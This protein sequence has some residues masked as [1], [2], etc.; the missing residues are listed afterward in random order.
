[1]R[2]FQTRSNIISDR[3]KWREYDVAEG[4]LLQ[5]VGCYSQFIDEE[6]HKAIPDT[7]KI[8][9]WENERRSLIKVKRAISVDDQAA[10]ADI[11]A[12]YGPMLRAFMARD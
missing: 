3:D 11:N 1:M 12:T 7:A 8:A 10:I 9:Q 4:T 2:P 5:L 6:E